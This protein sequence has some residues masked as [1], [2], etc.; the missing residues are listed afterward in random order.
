[1]DYHLKIRVN[2]LLAKKYSL[3]QK[4]DENQYTSTSDGGMNLF[5]HM[6]GNADNL[7]FKYDRKNTVKV[8]Q[9]S[10]QQEK[11]TVKELLR[12]EMGLKPKDSTVLKPKHIEV[13][14]DE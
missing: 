2:D 12:Q 14:W 1:M 13:E 8:I 4:R 11:K 6:Y 7:T 10:I 9:Q 5:I 3:R